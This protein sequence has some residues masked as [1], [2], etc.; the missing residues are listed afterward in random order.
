MI[1]TKIKTLDINTTEYFYCIRV[2]RDLTRMQKALTIKK[3]IA[4]LDYVKIKNF[5]LPKSFMKGMKRQR[6]EWQEIFLSHIINEY[7]TR[8][9]KVPQKT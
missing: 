6:K 9:H 2:G 5:Y 1:S 3:K 7:H 4:K 8:V